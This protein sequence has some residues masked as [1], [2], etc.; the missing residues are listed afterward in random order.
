MEPVPLCLINTSEQVH[1][2]QRKIITLG[3]IKSGGY[4]QDSRLR[5]NDLHITLAIFKTFDDK[6]NIFFF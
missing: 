3:F 1:L 4:L 5:K 6:T 2:E